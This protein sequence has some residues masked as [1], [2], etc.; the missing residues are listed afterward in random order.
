MKKITL[1]LMIIFSGLSYAQNSPT[2]LTAKK[3]QNFFVGIVVDS[4]PASNKAWN[5]RKS[6]AIELISSLDQGDKVV[7]LKARPGSPSVYGNTIIGGPQK[8]G[9]NEIVSLVS[10]LNKEW[11]FSANVAR[12]CESIYDIFISEGNGF[13]CLLVVLTNGKLSSNQIQRIIRTSSQV[14][15]LGGFASLTYDPAVANQN[16]IN[17]GQKNDVDI[18][19]ESNPGFANWIKSKRDEMATVIDKAPVSLKPDVN[20]LVSST[21]PQLPQVQET[22]IIDTPDDLKPNDISTH[23]PVDI[24]TPA[25]VD[26]ISKDV[27]QA[28]TKPLSLISLIIILAATIMMVTMVAILVIKHRRKTS[29]AYDNDDQE[30]QPSN[31]KAI[32]GEQDIDLG[33]IDLISELTLGNDP[34]CSIFIEDDEL[35][36]QQARIFRTRKGFKLQNLDSEPVI[37]NGLEVKNKKKV[38]LDLPADIQLPNGMMLNLYTET[39]PE[40]KDDNND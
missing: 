15:T 33:E 28:Q 23:A 2:E 20:N 29:M 11:L 37:V 22:N 26:D 18:L 34:G 14:K 9:S 1:T 12:A 25:E 13:K 17:A 40:I 30:H 6:R 32:V 27:R 36:P 16:I 10:V 7:V 8:T 39:N 24:N 31:L 35:S 5:I 19:L 3:S 21:T 38:K 4:S